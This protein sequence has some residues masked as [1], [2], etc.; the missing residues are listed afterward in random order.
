MGGG[1]R[2]GCARAGTR[3]AVFGG[4]GCVRAARAGARGVLVLACGV[5]RARMSARVAGGCEGHVLMPVFVHQLR[6]HPLDVMLGDGGL[7]GC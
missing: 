1:G 7:L 4:G 3:M 6:I 2:E 5:S